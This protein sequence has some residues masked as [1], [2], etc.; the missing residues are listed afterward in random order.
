MSKTIK[1]YPQHIHLPNNNEIFYEKSFDPLNPS[2]SSSDRF[3]T[4]TYQQVQELNHPHDEICVLYLGPNGT[5]G[6]EDNLVDN[7]PHPSKSSL[8]TL[9]SNINH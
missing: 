6:F 3:S 1:E 4:L 9:Q 8:L 5:R 2:L 7:Y